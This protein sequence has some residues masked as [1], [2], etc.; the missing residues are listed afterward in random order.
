MVGILNCNSQSCAYTCRL[1]CI[2][3]I[4]Y[5]SHLIYRHGH[6]RELLFF[7][8]GLWTSHYCAK[9]KTKP[10]PFMKIRKISF[11]MIGFCNSPHHMFNIYTKWFS[12]SRDCSSELPSCCWGGNSSVIH[13]RL[14][15]FSTVVV[16]DQVTIYNATSSDAGNLVEIQRPG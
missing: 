9:V 11:S 6:T 1:I 4:I 10:L 2:I 8:F 13:L 15:N 7:N 14:S 5:I 3:H 12:G 16:S